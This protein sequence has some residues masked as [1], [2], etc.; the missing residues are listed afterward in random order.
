MRA[1]VVGPQRRRTSWRTL[2]RRPTAG[3]RSKQ[4]QPS[5]PPPFLYAKDS[6]SQP[7][8]PFGPPPHEWG[9]SCLLAFEVRLSLF[10]EGFDAFVGVLRDEDPADRLALEGEAE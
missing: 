8:R 10:A 3:T 7:L 4:G 6:F 5:N 1:D 2:R 9:G